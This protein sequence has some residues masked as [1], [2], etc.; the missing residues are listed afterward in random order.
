MIGI[1]TSIEA[2]RS[3]RPA[4]L[5]DAVQYR[6][7]IAFGHR[8]D[9]ERRHLRPHRGQTRLVARTMLLEGQDIAARRGH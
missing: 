7:D 4:G 6:L 8:S 5:S 9:D 1:E 3:R 2:R